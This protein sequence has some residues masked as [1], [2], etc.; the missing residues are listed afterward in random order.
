MLFKKKTQSNSNQ[1]QQLE[2][3][4]EI[5]TELKVTRIEQNITLES[6]A[7]KTYIP[8]KFL[9]AIEAG[10]RNHLPEDVYIQAF[11]RQFGDVLGLN[12]AEIARSF[13]IIVTAPSP[14]NAAFET[15]NI[16]TFQLKPIHLYFVYIA[17][18]FVSV[19]TLSNLI[20]GNTMLQA[21]KD[22]QQDDIVA[23]IE[24]SNIG[25]DLIASNIQSVNY[26]SVGIEIEIKDECWLQVMVD[27]KIKFEGILEA[28]I[29]QKWTAKDKI[30]LTAGNAGGVFVSMN[31][32]ELAQLGELGQVRQ[33]SYSLN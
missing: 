7:V 24:L 3:L 33:V 19:N 11:I 6:I 15:L 2:R 23:S 29:S 4:Q 17:L 28:G 1:Q 26:Q 13:P 31:G 14:I 16:P 27:G 10:D 5:G 32:E 20:R 9:L 30:N 21:Q 25:D 12:G 22:N 8:K 18:V